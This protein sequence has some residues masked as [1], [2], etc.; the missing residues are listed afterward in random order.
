M[1]PSP[2]LAKLA[3]ATQDLHL[4]VQTL[5]GPNGCPWDKEQTHQS[6]APYSIEEIYEL[7]EALEQGKDAHILEELGD[8]LFQVFLH[9]QLAAETDRFDLADVMIALNQKMIRRH[10]HVFAQQKVANS[11]D[12]VRNWEKIK[13]LEQ[14]QT[15]LSDSQQDLQAQ[16]QI[17]DPFAFPEK[18]PALQTAHKIG[19]KAKRLDFDWNS[20]Q[21]V[22]G[23]L[24]EEIQELEE[25]VAA[26]SASGDQSICDK[27]QEHI[28]EEMGD[29]LF[30]AAQVARHLG[31][32]PEQALR[33]G[34][35]KFKNRFQK[36]LA[37]VGGLSQFQNL[38]REGKE[39]LWQKVKKS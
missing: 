9:A 29:L 21:E 18:L 13:A 34:N 37:T 10:P 19:V 6:L 20:A 26:A 15:P 27:A 1:T 32:E 33:K 2:N 14:K 17:S 4:T 39:S 23:K 12:V 8:V 25:A 28:Q 7:V 16:K 22:L 24:K 36:M 3:Q 38:P 5:R 11:Q 35:A 30:A 31:I